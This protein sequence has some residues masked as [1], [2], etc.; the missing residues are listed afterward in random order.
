MS[1]NNIL[2]YQRQ[3]YSKGHTAPMFYYYYLFIYFPETLH[4]EGIIVETSKGAHSTG[5]REF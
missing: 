5:N 4:T 2:Y 3:R 1:M